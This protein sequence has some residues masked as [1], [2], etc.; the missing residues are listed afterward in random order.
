MDPKG[1]ELGI[2][3]K[4]AV[5]DKIPREELR[6]ML[7]VKPEELFRLISRLVDATVMAPVRFRPETT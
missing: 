7:F 3:A 1:A 6:L 2:R 4:M 5:L